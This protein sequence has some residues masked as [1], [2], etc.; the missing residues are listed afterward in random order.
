MENFDKLK[1]ILADVLGVDKDD[2]KKN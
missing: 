2:I 1:D